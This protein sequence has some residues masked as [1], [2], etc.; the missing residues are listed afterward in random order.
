VLAH[1]ADMC[2]SGMVDDEIIEEAQNVSTT[3]ESTDE[4]DPRGTPWTADVTTA[5][6]RN[7]N[8]AVGDSF[9]CDLS[10]VADVDMGRRHMSS[11]A[12]RMRSRHL[13]Y[14]SE[15]MGRVDTGHLAVGVEPGGESSS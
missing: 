9:G 5:I 11:V 4:A 3:Q 6:F 12:R 7:G 13:D 2:Q 8:V 15:T 1:D 10:L 14:G